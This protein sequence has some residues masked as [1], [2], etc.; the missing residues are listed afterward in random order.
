MESLLLN[1]E[2]PDLYI[3]QNPVP[4]AYTLAIN[5]KKPFI[6]VHTSLVELLT[7]RELQAVLAHELGHLKCD[8][9]VWLTFANILTMGAYTVPGF[10]MVAGFLEEQLYR[11]LRAAELTCDRAALL[12]VQDPKVTVFSDSPAATGWWRPSRGQRGSRSTTRRCLW[13][14][15]GLDLSF[16]NEGL[17]KNRRGFKLFYS[18]IF[19][20]TAIH[21]SMTLNILAYLS[22]L[23]TWD[24]KQ[25]FVFV[26]AECETPQDAFIQV[27]LSV[28][29]LHESI[30]YLWSCNV[31][32]FKY[33]SG[34]IIVAIFVLK[35]TSVKEKSLGLLTQNFVK[36]F[37][38][39]K[40]ETISL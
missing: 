28:I 35:L 23:L 31:V 8:H 19:G 20:G 32:V 27:S 37:F 34:L 38:T 15:T 2:A 3:R 33:G 24:T 25:V 7:P 9:G 29:I 6:V 36:L 40:V 12:V 39:M 18:I 5:D 10:G 11:W 1:T 4:N 22:P 13:R 16:L 14:S 17:L 26:A 30:Y 21:V